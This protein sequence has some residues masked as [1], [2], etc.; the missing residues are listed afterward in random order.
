MRS[1]PLNITQRIGTGPAEFSFI[2]QSHPPPG[3]CA[4]NVTA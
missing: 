3:H 4:F 2:D 1:M